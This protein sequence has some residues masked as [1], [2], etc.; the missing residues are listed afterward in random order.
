MS[1]TTAAAAAMDGEVAARAN[2][3]NANNAAVAAALAASDTMKIGV[4]ESYKC[5][6]S[7]SYV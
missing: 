5:Y 7:F 1:A 3:A 2:A 4:S 6:V